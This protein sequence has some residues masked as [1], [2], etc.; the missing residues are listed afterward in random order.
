[1]LGIGIYFFTIPEKETKISKQSRIDKA[2]EQEFEM[3]KDLSTETVPRERLL[4][5]RKIAEN[6]LSGERSAESIIWEERGPNNVGGRTR[7]LLFDANDATGKTVWAGGVAGGLWHSTNIDAVDPAWTPVDDFFENIAVSCIVQHPNNPDLIY[8]GTGEGWFNVDALRGMGIWKTSDGG[9]NWSQLPSTNNSDFYFV[10]KMAFASD[11]TLFACTRN[12]GVLRSADDGG[13]W[14][15]VL[16]DG[17]GGG[18]SNRGADLEIAADGTIFA[19]LGIFSSDGVYRSNN[20]G[21]TWTYLDQGLPDTDFERIEI[22]CAPSDADRAYL[23]FQKDDGRTCL[24][25]YRTSDG[26]DTWTAV[27]NPSALGMSNFARNQA[28]YDLIAAVDPNNKDRLFIGGV[29]LHV[30]SDA[31]ANWTQVSQ[32]YGG[33]GF[34]YVHA[35]QHEILFY[36]GSS[37]RILFGN[38]GGV[39]LTDN[40]NSDTPDFDGKNT[41]YN[42]TQF[43]ACAIHPDANTDYYLAGAQDNGTQQFDQAGIDNTFEVTGGD[44]AYCHIDQDEP[45]IQISSYVYNAYRITN[46]NWQNIDRFEIGS[47]VGRFI[48]P[49]DYDSDANVL[50]GAG[51]NDEYTRVS[52]VGGGNDEAIIPMA[53]FGDRDISCVKVGNTANRVFFGTD[54]GEVFRVENAHTNSP[55]ATEIR[56]GSGYASSI[57]IE[58]G[59]DDHLLV[60]YSN[61][62]LTSVYETTDG[63]AN[64]TAVEGDLPDIPVRTALFNPN[65]PNQAM[66]GTDLGVWYTG[67][68]DGG[69]TVWEPASTGLANTRVD[70]L[71]YRPSDNQVIAA[72][73]GRGLFSTDFFSAPKVAFTSASAIQVEE[74]TDAVED[75]CRAY[76]DI[77]LPVRFS[78]LP[79]TAVTVYLEVDLAG[80]SATNE[81]DFALVGD[82]LIFDNSSGLEQSVTLRVYDDGVVESTMGEEIKINLDGGTYNGAVT[83]FT[84]NISETDVDPLS[85]AISLT[86]TGT[87][88][89]SITTGPFSGFY[90]DNRTQIIFEAAELI[91]LGMEAG[92]VTSLA[93]DVSELNSTTPYENFALGLKNS[94]QTSIGFETGFTTVYAGAYTPTLGWSEMIFT[95]DFMWDGTSK[96]V[97]QTCYDNTEYTANDKIL[98]TATNSSMVKYRRT[99]GAAGCSLFGNLASNNRPNIRFSQ[100][101]SFPIATDLTAVYSAYLFPGEP[102]YLYDDLGQLILSIK[103][104]D[105]DDLE[106]V[107]V[108][109]TRSGTA[110]QYPAWLDPYGVSDKAITIDGSGA[111]NYEV[112]LYYTA[113][114]LAA[115]G[116]SA[117]D[118]SILKTAGAIGD[119]TNAN[120]VIKNLNEVNANAFGA[121]GDFSFTTAFNGFSSFALTNS[122]ELVLPV[123]LLRFTANRVADY[124][125]LQ[126]TTLSEIN[127]KG[128]DVERS[129]DGERFEQIAFVEGQGDRTSAQ[130]Y[131]FKDADL[132]RSG[133]YYYR[134]KQIDF[135]GAIQ[136]SNIVNL[137]VGNSEN[138][139]EV[140]P[141]PVFDKFTLSTEFAA[142]ELVDLVLLDKAGRRVA[143]LTQGA[144]L[145]TQQEFDLAKLGLSAG[146]YVLQGIAETGEVI[147]VK[148][149]ILQ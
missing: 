125:L 126:W 101:G 141:N 47:S 68:L 27:D 76:K 15:K 104:L 3:T 20:N 31:G 6:K 91:A 11:G 110:I 19:S 79:A 130:N 100:P 144:A 97:V 26:G 23:L 35:D 13:S 124:H 45:N 39:F 10:Q 49:T 78:P 18:F 145:A 42:V 83:T 118:L 127:N 2:I 44:G 109:V 146:V 5:A 89:Q 8:F 30:S 86:T 67:D 147:F 116:L 138:R 17:T 132:I 74:D 133:N 139:F 52:D 16:G 51:E 149:L 55:S 34:P 9:A 24:G 28:W 37:T 96:L 81:D 80:S 120:T 43:Y 148:R 70:Q 66:L 129:F 36:P 4:R 53:L 14:T 122:T 134:L 22:A 65:D 121:T 71:K 64:W 61:Y 112:S 56:T 119:A 135:N 50:Y 136:Y 58:K 25:I 128:F 59:N 60:T 1:M 48:N 113:A 142:N 131:V 38:D 75:G 29:D 73:H 106:C 69:N 54:G 40:G 7:A 114:E 72:T 107:D 93:F 123:E 95:D 82:S 102:H 85:G 12:N 57:A 32:W 88:T 105:G 117:D 62:G 103:Q 92:P 90:E 140:Y 98:G 84:L 63:G 87:G 94:T 115:W 99:D 108:S 21:N 143:I 41:G 77:A 46:D 111:V 33:G 137:R